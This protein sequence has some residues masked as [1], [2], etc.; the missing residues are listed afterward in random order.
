MFMCLFLSVFCFK[1]VY[2]ACVFL[3]VCVLGFCAVVVCMCV[4]CLRV[5]FWFVFVV[6]VTL[7]V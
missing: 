6:S 1:E 4:V 5:T 3:F 2:V 7:F